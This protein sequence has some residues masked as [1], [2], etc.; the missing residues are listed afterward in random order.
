VSR[1][2]KKPDTGVFLALVSLAA[3]LGKGYVIVS[4]K[5][6]LERIR[7][8]T[9]Y[10]SMSRRTLNRHLAALERLAFINRQ[11]RS[12]PNRHGEIR[13]VSTLYTFAEHGILWI[14]RYRQAATIVLGRPRV[15]EMAHSQKTLSSSERRYAVN[16]PLTAQRRKGRS[17]PPRAGARNGPRPVQ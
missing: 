8:T 16:K 4:Q 12:K 14:K 3:H 13:R 11:Q 10:R 1:A 15:P 17:R 5:K 6:L 2:V 9:G 7:G